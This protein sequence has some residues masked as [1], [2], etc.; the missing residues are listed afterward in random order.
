MSVSRARGQGAAPQEPDDDDGNGG[1]RAWKIPPFWHKLNSFFLFP[2]QME[3]LIYS[4]I[5]ALC[6]YLLM[7]GGFFSL[8]VAGTYYYLTAKKK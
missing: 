2:F 4:I 8:F 5:L 6:S 7:L 1:S 3:P